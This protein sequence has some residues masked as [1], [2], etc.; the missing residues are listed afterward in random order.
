[1]TKFLLLCFIR[2]YDPEN[3]AASHSAIGKL[4]GAIGIICNLL[5]FLGKLL[6]GLLSGSVS[7][8]ADAVN[9]LS[10][11]ASSVI[12]FLGFRMAQRPADQNHPYGHARLEYLS[13]FVVATLILFIGF[14]LAKSSVE[15]IIH[16]DSVVFSLTA[17]LVMLVS[18]LVK[19]WMSGFFRSLGKRIQSS[20]LQATAADSRNDVIATSA[21]LLG[22]LIHRFFGV[23][24]DGWIGL[25]VALFILY[26]GVG[27]AQETVSPLLGKRTD[28]T[29]L[30]NIEQLV[31]NHEGILGIHDLLVHDYG[32]GQYFASVHVE[33]NAN[34]DPQICHEIIDDIECDALQKLNVNLVIH[35]DPVCT[36]DPE[37]NEMRTVVEGI[38]HAISPELSMHDF[39]MIRASKTPK[40]AFDLAVPFSMN[41]ERNSLQQR[42]DDAL[43][44]QGRNYKTI[45]RFD[46]KI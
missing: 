4:S 1:M 20:T 11:A 45:I 42:I 9:N 43:Q 31:L 23:N 21:V 30:D 14:E 41:K 44:S 35:Y 19:L 26:S 28:Q 10:D 38:I 13:G 3:P 22:C 8:I 25:L 17:L 36:D 24:L 15:R 40:L 12:T 6:A 2:N 27:I 7:I 16:P 32:P 33:L 34:T 18:I 39:R 5:L 37:L 46:A 29:L